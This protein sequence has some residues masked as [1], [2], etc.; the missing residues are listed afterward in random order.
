MTELKGNEE[1]LRIV[2]LITAQKTVFSTNNLCLFI[3][4]SNKKVFDFCYDLLSKRIDD[5]TDLVI[6]EKGIINI[7]KEAFNKNNGGTENKHVGNKDEFIDAMTD[8]INNALSTYK[9]IIDYCINKDCSGCQ[10]ESGN[11]TSLLDDINKNVQKLIV[12]DSIEKELN[13]EIYR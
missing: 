13:S 4:K 11:L 8:K 1:Y 10:K 2:N 3:N 9:Q 12:K 6:N 5:Y 7:I